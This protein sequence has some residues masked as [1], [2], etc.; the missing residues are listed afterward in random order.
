MGR[1][2][3]QE[4]LREMERGVEQETIEGNEEEGR[5]GNNSGKWEGR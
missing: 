2:A 5:T 4:E 1:E 3:E